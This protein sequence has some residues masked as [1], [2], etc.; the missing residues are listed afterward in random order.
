MS[1]RL[2]EGGVFPPTELSLPEA[3]LSLPCTP[4][5]NLT[6]VLHTIQDI[7]QREGWGQ[8]RTVAE[9]NHCIPEINEYFE[10]YL[11]IHQDIQGAHQRA[12]REGRFFPLSPTQTVEWEER[13]DA[14]DG[15]GETAVYLAS[16]QIFNAAKTVPFGR[17][18]TFKTI[19]LV[20]EAAAFTVVSDAKGIVGNTR[21]PLLKMWGLGAEGI[22]RGKSR[23]RETYTIDFPILHQGKTVLAC[24][25]PGV[26]NEVTHLHG[27]HEE[28]SHAQPINRLH[29]MINPSSWLRRPRYTDIRI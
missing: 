19:L 15:A 4:L 28:C 6:D 21:V 22:H 3:C 5:K 29:R 26:D 11:R 24:L 18:W 14:I 25:I 7:N 12:K 8:V 10:N 23:R 2:P 9:L 13:K 27:L 20:G 1:S 16:E 17:G